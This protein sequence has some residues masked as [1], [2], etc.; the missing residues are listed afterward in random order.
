MPDDATCVETALFVVVD[1]GVA[2]KVVGESVSVNS[3]V[4]EGACAVGAGDVVVICAGDGAGATVTAS[5]A[6]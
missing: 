4:D 5:T 3:E 6:V 2:T 1:A